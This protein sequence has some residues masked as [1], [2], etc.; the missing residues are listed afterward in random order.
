MKEI[1]WDAMVRKFRNTP[2]DFVGDKREERQEATEQA[3]RHRDGPPKH[4][5]YAAFKDF[6]RPLESI[7]RRFHDAY[8]FGGNGT[9]KTH[10]AAAA[11]NEHAA[12]FV[13]V[14]WLMLRVRRTFNSA[15]AESELDL[16]QELRDTP[17]LVLDDLLAA[18]KT[19]FGLS[20]LLALINGRIEDE[21]PT[22]V[23]CDRSIKELDKWDSS[24]ASRLAGFVPI[25]MAG[26][27]R[28][29]R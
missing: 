22:V 4:Y 16:I 15:T 28:R 3:L 23:T 18:Q 26:K 12:K 5:R 21:V 10:L 19:D 6:D 25:K 2:P 24:I 1:N 8:I 11:A 13:S 29:V 9:G 20:T 27:D 14:P 7:V 17:R